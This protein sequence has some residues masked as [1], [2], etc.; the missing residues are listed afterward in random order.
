MPVSKF[1]DGIHYE[2]ISGLSLGTCDVRNKA[3]GYVVFIRRG[4]EESQIFDLYDKIVFLPFVKDRREALGHVDGEELDPK[5]RAVRWT[6]GG[7]PQLKAI[8]K[9]TAT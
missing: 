2:A 9:E 5:F 1:P 6:D 8:I 7:Q 4:A 3:V